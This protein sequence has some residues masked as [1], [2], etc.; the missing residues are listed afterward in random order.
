MAKK[1]LK[2]PTAFTV[3]YI[4]LIFVAILTYLVPAG[5]YSKLQYN[6]ESEL[7]IVTTA[8]GEVEELPG[9]QDTLDALNIK[10]NVEK[11][12]D[13][14]IYR[15]VAIPNSYERVERN[16]QGFLSVLRAPISGVY[17]S[18]DIIMF[19]LILGGVIGVINT[20]G[21]F[22]A[23]IGAL[24]R[25]TRGKEYILIIVVTLLI[26]VGGTT[27]GLAEETIALYPILIPVFLATGYDPIVCI[28]SVY[29]GSSIGTM[30]S[31]VNPFS[32]VIASNAA[33]VTFTEGLWMRLIGLIIAITITIIYI[34]R[35][36]KKVK[37]DPEKSLTYS[38]REEIHERFLKDYDKSS[39]V[40]FTVR[41]KLM[42]SI[43][44]LTFIVM[45]LGVAF[46]GWWFTEM[47]ALFLL[48]GIILGFI[49]GMGEERFV[50]SFIGG[51]ADLVSV[52]LIVGVARAINLIMDQGMISDTILYY[53]SNVVE[54][55]NSGLFIIVILLLY[56]GLG[57][58]IPSSSGL[59][60]LSMPI[61]APLAD[62]VGL[63]RDII[64]S[65]Y[66]YGQGLIAF[67]TP[68][69]LIL[70]TLAMVH[71]GYNKWFKFILPLMGMIAALAAVLLIIQSFL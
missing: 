16:P 69:G 31:T 54:G 66:Q 52:A 1:K 24:S 21:S 68:T 35:Y 41:R 34:L 13:G 22:D 6:T 57:F 9:T 36:G 10:V 64:V 25:L 38:E 58:F 50:D 28:A 2:F 70:A 40:T 5:Q 17:E 11:F 65:A 18:V 14:S 48:V 26:G 55:M 7:F 45:T 12:R 30:F 3:L 44:A 33:G 23:G 8:R 59:A 43:F 20:T 27:F 56:I 62:S 39:E 46:W 29:M 71:V 53:S 37:E 4:V 15:P 63:S 51:A 60:V 42:L 67:I 19:I 49:S 32:S 47:T 61:M